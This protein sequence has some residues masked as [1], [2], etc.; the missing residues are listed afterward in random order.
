MGILCLP[1]PY[2]NSP[3][4]GLLTG[5]LLAH[6]SYALQCAL[7]LSLD[8]IIP[9]L[10]DPHLDCGQFLSW[11]PHFA[12]AAKA[13]VKLVCVSLYK[14]VES[15]IES[16]LLSTATL[17]SPNLRFTL[18]SYALLTLLHG[19][20]V[21]AVD[22][23]P[24]WGIKQ[25]ANIASAFHKS[26]EEA[27]ERAVAQRIHNFFVR[28]QTATNGKGKGEG[29]AWA[30]LKTFWISVV[31]RARYA[32][33]LEYLA[34]ID[35]G[36]PALSPLPAK[37]GN[38]QTGKVQNE[39]TGHRGTPLQ[40]AAALSA[41]SAYLEE[42]VDRTQDAH[43]VERLQAHISGVPSSALNVLGEEERKLLQRGADHLRR[44][45][46]KVL[47]SAGAQVAT[48][49]K[50]L[51]ERTVDIYEGLLKVCILFRACSEFIAD[52]PLW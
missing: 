42:L 21:D 34:R 5:L 46:G 51:L 24:D 35:G 30:Q 37:V 22:L 28:V 48:L 12:T 23:E 16:P 15:F 31:S 45:V 13:Q 6:L 2:P 33:G 36:A 41:A 52:A 3:P 11:T 10:C 38:I 49:L 26:E 18:R 7:H 50:R 43:V 20:F 47:P 9:T 27:G 44:A 29:K 4:D 14:T 32:E 19:A 25:A 40:A 39:E 8:E 17:S 1:S